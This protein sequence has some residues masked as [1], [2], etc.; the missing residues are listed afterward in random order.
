MLGM[1][2]GESKP[3]ASLFVVA[4]PIGNLEDMSHRA[5]R[6]L[7]E[8]D[9]VAAEDTRRTRVLFDHYGI[10]TPLIALHEHNELALAPQLVQQLCSGSSLA[11]VSDAGTPLLSDPGY[12][13]LNLAIAAGIQVLSIPGA[14]ALTAAL[15]IAGLPTD[16]FVFEGFLPAKTAARKAS[17]E[18]LRQEQRTL[19]FFE[20]S[21]RVLASLGAMAEVFGQNRPAAVCRELTKRYETTLRGGLGSLHAAVLANTDQ[22]KGEFVIVVDGAAQDMDV[23]MATAMEMALA[24]QEFLSGSQAARV[25]ARLCDVDRRALYRLLPDKGSE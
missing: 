12:R 3:A 1:G 13:L 23:S 2:I 20:S 15:S 14:S 19:V 7:S 24:L 18:R 22:Q 6:V 25:A 9:L 16:R 8:V 4:T 5:V 11:L 21:H 17:L 10:S